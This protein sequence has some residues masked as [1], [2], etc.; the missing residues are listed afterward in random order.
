MERR[1]PASM[2]RVSLHQLLECSVTMPVQDNVRDHAAPDTPSYSS[3]LTSTS[4]D[5]LR[6]LGKR[7]TTAIRNGLVWV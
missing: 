3:R 4:D 6:G 2:P 1:E 5:M 7:A